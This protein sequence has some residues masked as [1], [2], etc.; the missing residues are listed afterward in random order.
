LAHNI[1]ASRRVIVSQLYLIFDNIELFLIF[2]GNHLGKLKVC[3]RL[4]VYAVCSHLGQGVSTSAL[5][6]ITDRGFVVKSR[7]MLWAAHCLAVASLST[8]EIRAIDKSKKRHERHCQ[9][10]QHHIASRAALEDDS[11]SIK[12]S[13]PPAATS[14]LES[15][16]ITRSQLKRQLLAHLI[17]FPL[18]ARSAGIQ[19]WIKRQSQPLLVCIGVV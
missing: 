11:H 4:S 12:L 5:A 2:T 10:Q 18:A 8:L 17:D 15:P 16:Q 14:I 6:R 13:S 3:R 19:V 9:Q 7:C 1:I